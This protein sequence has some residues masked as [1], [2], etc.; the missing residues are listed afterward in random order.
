MTLFVQA[1]AQRFW[2]TSAGEWIGLILGGGAIIAGI[3]SFVYKVYI[4]PIRDEIA[5][6]RAAREKQFGE[7]KD[8]MRTAGDAAH[9][10]AGKADVLERSLASNSVECSGLHEKHGK[11]EGRQEA[12]SESLR[13]TEMKLLEEM[14]AVRERLKGV[15]TELRLMREQK[16]SHQPTDR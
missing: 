14:G 6:E 5:E 13:A 4:K 9:V 16:N 7:A 3:L 1:V 10:A 12:M 2:P 8:L 15:E 11:L